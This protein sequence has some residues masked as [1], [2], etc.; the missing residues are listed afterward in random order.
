MLKM[1][2]IKLEFIIDPD[3][4]IFFEKDTRG[5]ISYISSRY[6]NAVWVSIKYSYLHNIP[7]GNVKKLL[8]DFFDKKR[9]VIHYENLQLYLRL[10]LKPKKIHRVLESSA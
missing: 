10:G 7:I 9:H 5:R 6:R 8:P 2:K 4:Y 3:M 1:T